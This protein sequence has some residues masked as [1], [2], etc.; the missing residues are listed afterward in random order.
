MNK[1]E[2]LSSMLGKTKPTKKHPYIKVIGVLVISAIVATMALYVSYN[3][4]IW[5]RN[6]SLPIANIEATSSAFLNQKDFQKPEF[7][8][9]YA[10]VTGSNFEQTIISV[11]RNAG[12]PLV[13][14][15]DTNQIKEDKVLIASPPYINVTGRKATS[16]FLLINRKQRI[17]IEALWQ[18]SRGSI[19]LKLGHYYTIATNEVYPEDF[20]ILIIDGHGWRTGLVNWYKKMAKNYNKHSDK[21]L[22]ILNLDEFMTWISAL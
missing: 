17:R 11:A 7:S 6:Q 14:V 19:D 21:K 15:E 9:A 2:K 13:A 20:V 18:Q 10:H 22:Y 12:F 4:Q 5:E 1:A 8:Q 3:T 16:D